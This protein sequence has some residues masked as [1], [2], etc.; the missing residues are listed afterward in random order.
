MKLR[1]LALALILCSAFPAA[2]DFAAYYRLI[3]FQQ[4]GLGVKRLTLTPLLEYTASATNIATGDSISKTVDATGYTVFS[5]MIA[6]TYRVE[7]FGPTRTTTLTNSFGTNVTGLVNA[8]DYLTLS[9]NLSNG[10]FAYS[11]SAAR[12]NGQADARCRA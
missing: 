11:Q 2:A 8:K 6:G 12:Q 10:D 3:N 7:F 9:T 1:F 4:A 5:N